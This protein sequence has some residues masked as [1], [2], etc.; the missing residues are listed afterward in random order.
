MGK[1]KGKNQSQRASNYTN[2]GSHEP[3]A[4]ELAFL[5]AQA[6]KGNEPAVSKDMI[7]NLSGP[8]KKQ[9]SAD[10]P[11][12]KTSRISSATIKPI[13]AKRHPSAHHAAAVKKSLFVGRH[14]G[15]PNP[16]G[17]AHSHFKKK[18]PVRLGLERVEDK[19]FVLSSEFQQETSFISS[20]QQW[21]EAKAAVGRTQVHHGN[22]NAEVDIVMGFDFGTSSSKVII[23]DSGRRTAY[24]FPFGS[25]SSSGNSYLVPTQLY[26]SE[27]GT[28]GLSSGD[29]SCGNIKSR[30]MI[31]SNEA[32]FYSTRIA[33]S[34]SVTEVAA[35]YMAQVI[36]FSR[37]WFLKHTEAIY[38]KT[39]IHWHIN[40]GMPSRSYDNKEMR[41][42]FHLIGMA[43]WR[44]SLLPSPITII[45]VKEYL[46]EGR[47]YCD[48]SDKGAT[49]IPD[50]VKTLWLH[51]DYV[52]VHPEVIMEVVGYA[53]SP[54]R[55]DG[56][57][58]I[59]DVGATTLDAATFIIHER[60]GGDI[61]PILSTEVERLGTLML[62]LNR[63]HALKVAMEKSLQKIAAINPLL[64]LPGL[65]HYG[66]D[67]RNEDVG[68]Y[69]ESF[70][71]ECCKTIGRTIKDTK[72]HRDP[73][74]SVWGTELPVFICGGG[75]R[76]SSYRQM[77]REM[78][79]RCAHAWDLFR[80]FAIK[81][82]PKPDNLETP[83]LSPDEY[84]RLA[85]AY[86]LSFTADEIGE[87]I[88]QSKISDVARQTIKVDPEDRFVSKDMC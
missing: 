42:L 12:A 8:K 76:L 73:Y 58:L 83:D 88:A 36:R 17:S 61:F 48:P 69:D 74:S 79:E 15:K 65:S 82:I 2:R 5:R 80:G 1:N 7:D 30:L 57:H 43:A 67:I 45:D 28:L 34:I 77:I 33:Q 70:F 13:Q 50:E 68:S 78:G 6:S 21:A 52:N 32:V 25:S 4:M 11:P 27:D 47:R 60:E 53:R 3:T 16:S 41:K 14:H 22:Y 46:Q 9:M 26:I 56:L 51:P 81:K 23:R 64:P 87:V 19:T 18:A 35:G 86:G 63:V 31:R 59:V 71:S 20:G 75:G 72:Y 24:A 39:D 84:D 85:V 10:M 66:T 55:T 29:H 54:L 49:P 40:V 38:K 37:A 62:H 44:L